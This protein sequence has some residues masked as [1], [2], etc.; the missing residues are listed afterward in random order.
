MAYRSWRERK[1]I[2]RAVIASGSNSPLE[3]FNLTDEELRFYRSRAERSVLYT[4]VRTSIFKA[5]YKVIKKD[6]FLPTILWVAFV[7]AAAMI[8]A[9][10][11]YTHISDENRTAP[12]VGC[13]T[14]VVAAFGW[15]VTSSVSHANSVRQNTTNLL[16]ARFS[17][18]SFKD[19][20]HTFH[21]KFGYGPYPLVS[22]QDARTLQC[23]IDE[24]DQRAVASIFYILNY[25]EFISAGIHKGEIDIEIVKDHMRS[26]FIYYYDKCLPLINESNKSNPKSAEYFIKVTSSFREP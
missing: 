18:A 20:L 15:A 13:I 19:S 4:V 11:I 8:S 5:N 21:K 1:D 9:F 26:T 12:L 24:E 6:L 3:K 2:I 14:A 23:S 22:L 7:V 10:M 25:Y 16:F 17:Q